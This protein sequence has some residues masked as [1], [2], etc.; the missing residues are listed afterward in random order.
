MAEGDTN[1]TGAAGG[2]QSGTR[3]LDSDSKADQVKAEP[4][5]YVD[6]QAVDEKTWLKAAGENGYDVNYLKATPNYRPAI[7]SKK[8][9][10]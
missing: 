1:Q 8:L 3:P 5:F 10:K 9:S 7:N 2:G 6:G 4:K